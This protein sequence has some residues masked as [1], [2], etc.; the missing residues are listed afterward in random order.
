MSFPIAKL[1]EVIEFIRG[2]TFKPEDTVK[3]FSA[4]SVIVM[5]TKNIQVNGLDT[6]DLIAVHESFARREEQILR[7][8]DLLMSSANS[9][10]L[11]G[12]TSYVNDLGYKS[13]A[14]G[15]I[16]IVRGIDLKIDSRYLYHWITAPKIQLQI[17]LCGRQTTN[18][19]NLDVHRFKELEIP[20][21]PLTEQKRIAAILDKADSMRRKRQQAIKLADEFLRAVFLEMFGDPVT[22]SKGWPIGSIRELASSVSYGTSEKAHETIGEFPVLRM[23]NITYEGKW[24][25]ISLKYIDLDEK[26]KEKYLVS[27]GDLL[28]NRTNSKELV[29]KTAV[30]ER[31]VPMAYAGYLIRLRTNELA[32]PYYIAAYLNSAHGKMTLLNMCKSIVGMANINAQELQDIKIC[33]PPIELQNKFAA[34]TSAVSAHEKRMA[35]THAEMDAL[36]Q[37]LSQKAFSGQL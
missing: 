6:D 33:I 31:T 27:P 32:N 2:I 29:G 14:G 28:F 18:I 1:G 24:D 23:M 35:D 5:R 17:R 30:Y 16:S 3:P 34:I 8:G 10:E 15:F 20:V 4:N 13:T 19:S 7:P 37:S 9:F 12:K 25:F 22:N 26:G 36:F 11:V 21:P